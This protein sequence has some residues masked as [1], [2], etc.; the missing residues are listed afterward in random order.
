MI[1]PASANY[2]LEVGVVSEVIP[3]YVYERPYLHFRLHF[4]LG[5]A[6]KLTYWK[7]DGSVGCPS[8]PA[9]GPIV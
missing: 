6:T 7:S 9:R 8:T 1:H 2:C 5:R 3:F 4:G